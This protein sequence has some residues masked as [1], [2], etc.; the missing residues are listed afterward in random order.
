MA[1]VKVGGVTQCGNGRRAADDEVLNANICRAACR[2]AY[3]HRSPSRGTG[4]RRAE[5]LLRGG[6]AGDIGQCD[7]VLYRRDLREDRHRDLGRR[8]T[9]YIETD[10]PMKFCD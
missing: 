9:A 8:A 6:D 1:L 4:D 2:A 5:T 3:R 7:A 10:R